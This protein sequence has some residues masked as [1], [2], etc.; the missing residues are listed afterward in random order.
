MALA[1]TDRGPLSMIHNARRHERIVIDP[2]VM[3][4]KPTIRGTRI[5]VEL[6]LRKLGAGMTCE[7]I[8][9]D[10]PHLAADDIRAAHAFAAD[11]LADEA[12]ILAEP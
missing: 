7:E 5:T 2:R 3:A 9:A 6:I 12:V 4:G 11:Y 1:A 10:H 8:V